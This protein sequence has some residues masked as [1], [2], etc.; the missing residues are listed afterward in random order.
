MWASDWQAGLD[1]SNYIE[2][3]AIILSH[4]RDRLHAPVS[5]VNCACLV[6]PVFA[7]YEATSSQLKDPHTQRHDLSA[8][9]ALFLVGLEQLELLFTSNC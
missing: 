8:Q 3:V 1:R 5:L 2:V 6:M 4:S 7:L 9:D